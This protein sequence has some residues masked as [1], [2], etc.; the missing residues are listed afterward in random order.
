MDSVL[1]IENPSK[2]LRANVAINLIRTLTMTLLSFLT[3][4]YVTRALG[5]QVFGLYTWANTFVYY[6]LVLAKISI[7]NIAIRECAKVKDDKA[8]LSHKAQEFFVLQCITTLMSFGLLSVLC[9]TVPALRESNSIIFLLSINFLVGT[10]SFEWI[11]VT[12]EKHFYVT[13]RSILIIAIT[14]TMTFLFIKP[15]SYPINELYIYAGITISVTILTSICNLVYLRR[16]ITLRKSSPYNFKPYFKPLLT[17]F[18]ISAF[19]TV[20]NQTDAFLLGFLDSSKSSVGAYSVGVKGIDIVITLI[21]SLYVVFMP[22]AHYYYNKANKR[23]YG[24][25]L[26]YSFNITFFIAVPAIATM[27]TMSTPITALISGSSDAAAGQ[28][29]DANLVLSILAIMMLTYSVCDSIYTQILLPSKKEKHYMI[30]LAGGVILNVGGSLLF[31]LLLFKDRPI[32][33]VAI[34]TALADVFM[35][36]Y[37]L[38]V[39]WQYA[40]IAIFRGN[41]AKILIAGLL[42]AI[43]AYFFS[44]FLSRVIV[45]AGMQLWEAYLISLIATTA[46]SALIYIGSLA[47]LKENLVSLILFKK[48]AKEM[49]E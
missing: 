32:I 26:R 18:L 28:Y 9:F 41:T 4:P 37:L 23:P 1:E 48:T 10:F 43:F 7:P 15:T 2:K 27:A 6:F 47:L 8:A 3:F 11:F 45:E 46:I 24:N 14:A 21:T 49:E 29:N 13:V 38:A 42:V 34:A 22:R 35:F 39:T 40:R 30:A 19:L 25:L 20:Y 44:P 17:F 5:D 31:G 33:G 12:L 16:F 36:V